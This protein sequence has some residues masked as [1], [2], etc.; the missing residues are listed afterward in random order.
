MELKRSTK[1]AKEL[2]NQCIQRFLKA[3]PRGFYDQNYISWERDF[4]WSAHEKWQE[5]LNKKEFK[6]LMSDGDYEEVVRRAISV[7]SRTNLLYPYER[8]AL[9]EAIKDRDGAF[10]FAKGLYQL[11]FSTA[12]LS[13]RF[14]KWCESFDELPG[15]KVAGS[16]PRNKKRVTSWPVLTV[17]GFLARPE[18]Y[19]Y[20]KPEETKTAAHNYG[21]SFNLDFKPSWEGYARYL[22][23]CEEIRTDLKRLK[24]RDMIDIQS[25]IW[26]QGSDEY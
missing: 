10:I 1:E 8:L 21:F 12:D 4:K 7:E 2:K 22:Q 24:A 26:V 19:V 9:S 17:F 11:L 3:F 14:T 13:K 18:T 5:L 16:L 23:F 15:I 6:R 20:L 25:F